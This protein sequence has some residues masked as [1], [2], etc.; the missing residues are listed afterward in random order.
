MINNIID[1][2]VGEGYLLQQHL[3]QVFNLSLWDF[4]TTNNKNV[5]NYPNVS[6][7]Q[8]LVDLLQDKYKA[9]IIITNGAKNA[10]AASFFALYQNDCSH[11]GLRTPF[12]SQLIPLIKAHRLT[13]HYSYAGSSANL[14]V[15]PNNPDNFISEP[16]IIDR[17]A[18]RCK[19]RG[20]PLIHD[21]AYYTHSYLPETYPLKPIGDLQIFS[22]SKMLGL[23]GLRMGFIV[24]HNP[25]FYQPLKQ[26]VDMMTVGCSIISQMFLYD[27][28]NRMKGYPTLSAKFEQLNFNTLQKNKKYL[29]DH[30][31]PEVLEVPIDIENQYGMFGWLKKGNKFNFDKSKVKVFD[32]K[33]F[34]N[35]DYI[36]INLAFDHEIIKEIVKRLNEI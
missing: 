34:G 13:P 8:P 32:G 31:N 23:S 25:K 5:F 7:Y 21:A 36:R 17:F 16:A 30:L 26:Y 19:D 2:S 12:W 3:D 6:G 11:L 4:S 29:L 28:L 22:I 10:L 35:L 20:A 14:L 27:L 1:A 18:Q 9:P 24:C 15:L 33:D